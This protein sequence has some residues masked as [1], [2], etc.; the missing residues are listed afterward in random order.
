MYETL[1]DLNLSAQEQ[2]VFIIDKI[3]NE[4][5]A[6]GDFIKINR[7]SFPMTQ[8]INGELTSSWLQHT[9][10]I[11][12]GLQSK[13]PIFETVFE[14]LSELTKVQI[15]SFS[16]ELLSGSNK[17]VT[18]KECYFSDESPWSINKPPMD[19]QQ[20]TIECLDILINK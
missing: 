2:H 6:E 18:S 3:P 9:N 12:L 20:L 8:H 10:K 16:I 15:R 7:I 4:S 17:I 14:L 13:S 11:I 1:L 19:P 5:F